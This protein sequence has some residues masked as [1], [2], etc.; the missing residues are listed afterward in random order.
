[1][2][3]AFSATFARW[4]LIDKKME[5]CYHY[6]NTQESRKPF[7]GLVIQCF[8]VL[9][10]FY[11]NHEDSLLVMQISP[12][13]Y[14]TAK[15]LALAQREICSGGKPT[16]VCLECGFADYSAFYRAYV[17]HF[18][19]KPSDKS[20]VDLNQLPRDLLPMRLTRA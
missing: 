11:C 7:Y 1:M 4:F 3:K 12:K 8:P 18:G 16:E 19:K 15:R 6:L 5:A 20:I 17:A 10:R 9:C 13:R 2:E 14:I